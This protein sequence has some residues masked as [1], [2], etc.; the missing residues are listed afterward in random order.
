MTAAVA[1]AEVGE[2]EMVACEVDGAQVLICQV[3]GRFYAVHNQCS[4]ARQMLHGGTLVGHQ[5]RCPLHGGR[6]DV[7]TGECQGPPATRPIQTLPIQ[8]EKGRVHVDVSALA[9]RPRPRFGPLN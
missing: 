1:I 4:H 8:L 2:G 3:G 6:F 9:E 7:R 5:I